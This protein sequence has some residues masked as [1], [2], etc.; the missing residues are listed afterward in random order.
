MTS[1]FRNVPNIDY[2]NRNFES[3]SSLDQYVT[4]KNL[5][6]RV[7]LRSDIF[8]N[9]N[10]FEKYQIIGDE[11]P[12]NV[13][14]KVYGDE[15]LDWVILLSNNIINIQSEWPLSQ[16]AFDEYLFEKY[17]AG[18]ENKDQVYDIIYNGVHHY[19][20]IRTKNSKGAVVLE[21]GIRFSP[22]PRLNQSDPGYPAFKLRYLDPQPN[23]DGSRNP[24]ILQ[25]EDIFETVTNY[26]YE[27]LLEEEKRNI[28]VLKP[29]YLGIIFNDIEKT[30]PYVEG[31]DQYISAFLKRVDDI[32]LYS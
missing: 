10:Y 7:E 6:K 3:T 32:R 13:A 25:G 27:V 22:Q 21:G 8:G 1:Y 9:L 12:D 28:F 24:V 15:I 31:S 2:V 30:M 23:A 4:T 18:I 14:Y 19:E 5:F 11:R 26:Q 29:R 20:S 16:E 17:G